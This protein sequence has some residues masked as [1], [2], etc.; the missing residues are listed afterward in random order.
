MTPAMVSTRMLALSDSLFADELDEGARAVAALLH[1][2]A[3]V[4][5]DAV[6]EV[7][8]G[9]ARL[10]HHEDLV[11]ADA[12]AAVGQALPLGRREID[13]LADGVDDDEVIAGAVHLGKVEFHVLPYHLCWL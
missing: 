3:I 7:A 1:F 5:I 12:E 10:F 8:A 13:V 11:G 2:A 6:A 4:V 9:Q